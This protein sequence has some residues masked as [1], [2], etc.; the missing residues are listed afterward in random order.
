VRIMEENEIRMEA[1]RIILGFFA[2]L[3]MF[4]IALNML[5]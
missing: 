5:G 2:I 4:L 1:L 3:T